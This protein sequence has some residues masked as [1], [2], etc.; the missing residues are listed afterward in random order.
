MHLNY[1]FLLDWSDNANKI[2]EPRKRSYTVTIW[3][4][5]HW[6]LLIH[7]T[8]CMKDNAYYENYNRWQDLYRWRNPR[9]VETVLIITIQCCERRRTNW[10]WHLPI[11]SVERVGVTKFRVLM[12]GWY[13]NA[14][15]VRAI[16][17]SVS[18]LYGWGCY[19]GD[20]VIQVRVLY[21]WV[22][23][24]VFIAENDV[25]WNMY[26]EERVMVDA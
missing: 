18:V 24:S 14:K 9:C 12:W 25:G 2:Q 19:M 3:L 16:V 11:Q 15:L 8:V 6:H 22:C 23:V 5:C 20:F 10:Q 4:Q 26:V 1:Y 7:C 13:M 17:I 21:G